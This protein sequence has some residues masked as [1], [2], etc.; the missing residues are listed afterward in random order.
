MVIVN[1]SVV[2]TVVCCCYCYCNYLHKIR[3][4]GIICREK[5]LNLISVTLLHNFVSAR[6]W[7]WY[8]LL[9]LPC[10]LSIIM[11]SLI[12]AANCAAVLHSF[13]CIFSQLL[14]LLHPLLLLLMLMITFAVALSTPPSD[15]HPRWMQITISVTLWC[16]N[17][18]Q[19]QLFS[20][21]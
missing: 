16:Q 2:M 6:S 12:F 13:F 10:L 5:V 1:A 11:C 15:D 18:W 19:L 21:H 3:L 7:G 14:Q 17:I 20:T 9:M 4:T 8:F